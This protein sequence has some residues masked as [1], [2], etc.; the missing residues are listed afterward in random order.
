AA[1]RSSSTDPPF[2]VFNI[3]NGPAPTNN[4]LS[5]RESALPTHHPLPRSQQSGHASAQTLRSLPPLQTG[6]PGLSEPAP[7]PYDTDLRQ[8][9]RSQME[10]TPRAE[11]YSNNRH[12]ANTIRSVTTTGGNDIGSGAGNY[13]RNAGPENSDDEPIVMSAT[14][15][16]GQ[17]WQPQ[18]GSEGE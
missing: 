12:A 14:S 2:P 18:Y 8:A 6:I 1:G 17:M 9:R 15:F 7:R 5:P 11:D 4:I 10:T 16:P 3:P 13:G